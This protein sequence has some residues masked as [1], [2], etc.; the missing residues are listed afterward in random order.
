MKYLNFAVFAYVFVITLF[1]GFLQTLTGFGYA[2]AAAPLLTLVM[3]PKEVVMYILI[4]GILIKGALVYRTRGQGHFRD[5]LPIFIASF[6]GALPGAW[7]MTII[8]DSVLKI[9]IGM[10]LLTATLAIYRRLTI[11]KD[12]P[13]LA[14]TLVGLSSG[15][16]ASTTSLNGP[17]IVLYYMGENSDKDLIRANLAR[18]FLLG[19]SASIVMSFYFGTLHISTLLPYVALSLPALGLGLWAGEKVFKKIDAT[20]FRRLAL[21]VISVSGTLCIVMGLWSTLQR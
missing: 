8:S 7:V 21:A 16:L 1:S 20:M 9:A 2:L 5:I 11:P 14:K 19:N 4:T 3:S 17:P 15:F 18:Y 6:A 12:H 10:I 13:F